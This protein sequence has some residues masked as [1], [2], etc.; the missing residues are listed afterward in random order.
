MR[1]STSA[2]LV[3]PST[4]TA[5]VYTPWPPSG[6]ALPRSIS[7]G[8]Q[9]Q[10]I[11]SEFF[12]II[13]RTPP[14]GPPL[15][16][17]MPVGAPPSVWAGYPIQA[18]LFQYP[19]RTHCSRPQPTHQLS[20]IVPT[21]SLGPYPPYYPT[22][23]MGMRKTLRPPPDKFTGLGPVEA[24][25]FIICCVMAFDSPTHKFAT[26]HQRVSY[27]ASHFRTLLM[28]WWQPTSFWNPSPR[29][30]VIGVSLWNS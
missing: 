17:P 28:L 20:A 3:T 2:D 13:S 6:P 22:S 16:Y 14:V 26:D 21:G 23:R 18:T 25:P 5:A 15:S 8:S 9:L 29:S 4:R 10:R 12:S 7:L 11:P 30:A 24:T 27:A 1:K 19:T